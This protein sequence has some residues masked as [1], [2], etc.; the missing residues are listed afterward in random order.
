ML[1]RPIETTRVT[2]KVD[3]GPDPNVRL[4]DFT[5]VNAKMQA[6]LK[7]R[8]LTASELLAWMRRP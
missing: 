2:G 5:G 6:E 1:R 4:A 8:F 7:N 3:C